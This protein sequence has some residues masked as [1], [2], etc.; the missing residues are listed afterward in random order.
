MFF[1]DHLWLYGLVSL[2][3]TVVLFALVYAGLE[4]LAMVLVTLVVVV[5]AVLCIVAM[6]LVTG[7]STTLPL[8]T[9]E[10]NLGMTLLAIDLATIFLTGLAV[11]VCALLT[12]LLSCIPERLLEKK[13]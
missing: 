8:E 6:A 7:S 9:W 13:S 12:F 10:G 11:P 1:L 3:C 2:A 5:A 4:S